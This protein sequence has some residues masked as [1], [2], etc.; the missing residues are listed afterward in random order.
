MTTISVG[1]TMEIIAEQAA[2]YAAAGR[3]DLD[4]R[5]EAV[6][7]FVSTA[8]DGPG[9]NAER[10]LSALFERLDAATETV[11]AS[12]PARR[13]LPD[14]TELDRQKVFFAAMADQFRN[15]LGSALA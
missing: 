4:E 12:N 1:Q 7:D 13:G 9:T 14:Q 15:R 11:A 10:F 6:A 2:D 3:P 8:I 5:V